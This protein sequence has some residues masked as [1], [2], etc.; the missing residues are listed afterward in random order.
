MPEHRTER[1]VAGP[2]S[3]ATSRTFWEGF[4]P[5]A[6]RYQ[7]VNGTLRTVF[8]VERDWST[9]VVT[10]RQEDTTAHL[11]V[12]G[13]GDLAAATEQTARFLALDID[14]TDWPAVGTRDQVIAAAQAKLPGLRPCGFHSP[15]EAA[16][17]AVLSQRLRVPQAAQLRTA[18][19][20]R[21]GH[22]GAFPAPALLR[23]L[24]LNL[25]GRKA[26]Y[27]RTVADA[28]L[29]GTLD[30]TRLR[31]LDPAAAVAQVQQV[32]GLGPFAAELVVL[33]GANHPDAVPRHE[34]QLLDEI[35]VQYGPDATLDQVSPA[36]QPFRTW[37]SVHLRAIRA[38]HSTT[39]ERD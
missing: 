31:E 16:T 19:I 38:L 11:T 28:A 2:W 12:T 33:R 3:L 14:A 29:D 1:E 22:E 24:E 13:E 36:W 9:A 39:K 32:K 8:L 18:L 30:G 4:G 23:T 20:D 7:P 6:L 5:A 10:V 15:Y 35:T 21:H 25:P 17:W 37:A 27:L 26:E 34:E